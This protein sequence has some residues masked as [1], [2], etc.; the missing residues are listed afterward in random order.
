[1]AAAPAP[2]AST[3]LP[4]PHPFR[5]SMKSTFL[6]LPFLAWV[7]VGL[8]T[9]PAQAANPAPVTLASLLE[10]MTDP[11]AVTRLPHPSYRSLQASSYNRESVRRDQPGWFADSD[12][13]GFLRRETRGGRTEWVVLEHEGPGCLTKIWTPFFHYDLA[14]HTGPH[15]RIYLDGSE[16]PVFDEPFIPLLTGKGSVPSGPFAAFT[17]RAGNLGLP[18]AFSR[19]CRVAFSA[20]PFYHIINYRAYP[21]GTPV[22]S[23]RREHLVGRRGR[24]DLRRRGAGRR[25]PHPLRNRHRRLLRMGRRR[26]PRSPRRILAP[27]PRQRAGG[28]PGR[29]H[30]GI[31]HLHPHPGPGCHPVPTAPA[32]GHGVL[33]RN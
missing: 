32:H 29:S 21:P 27:L 5:P 6:S 31:Q 14:N 8:A 7:L 1:M 23:F 28:R 22:E 15:L 18:I 9:T 25:L 10:E 17:A 13:V 19:S 3:P 12:G 24:E 20:A 26:S 16:E 30:R 33:L 4:S 2:C 11:F